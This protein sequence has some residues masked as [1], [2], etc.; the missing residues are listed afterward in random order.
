MTPGAVSVDRVASD[1]DTVRMAGAVLLRRFFD[2]QTEQGA[3]GAPY[4]REAIEVIAGMLRAD[5]TPLVQKVLADGLR[6][7]VDLR[8]ADLQN[9]KLR[10]A[11]IGRKT[12]E[13]R[14][15]DLSGADLFEADCTG[16]SFK[17]VIAVNT[18]FYRAI[19][20]ET[21]FTDADCRDA[22]FRDARLTGS[23]LRGAKIGGAKFAGAQG[24]P[25]D[26]VVLLDKDLVGLQGARVP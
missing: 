24:I 3:A 8:R 5:Q 11:Y 22:D 13:K 19:L 16:A 10:N 21:V 23:K 15:V 12:G 18:V 25:D 4:I 17:D 14:V 7:A 9:C 20:E 26:V 1:N 6:Y 2:Q